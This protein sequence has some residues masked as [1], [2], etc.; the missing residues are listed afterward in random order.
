MRN[1]V[2]LLPRGPLASLAH[3]LLNQNSKSQAKSQQ[4]ISSFVPISTSFFAFILA[5]KATALGCHSYWAFR[6]IASKTKE[7]STKPD[8]PPAGAMPGQGPGKLS[9]GRRPCDPPA[10][11]GTNHRLA[12]GPV[13]REPALL[14]HVF[15]PS[16]VEE[17]GFGF[18]VV[19]D[20]LQ[21]LPESGEFF[22]GVLF[23]QCF[24]FYI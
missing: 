13:G 21:V 17:I 20:R 22:H 5:V 9:G 14:Q 18:L 12:A 11:P 15:E 19:Q 7:P 1:M 3:F 6:V 2:R 16:H 10:P 8:P 4:M 24:G 23:L